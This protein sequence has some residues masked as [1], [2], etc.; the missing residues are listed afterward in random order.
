M[1][2]ATTA[3]QS[4]LCLHLTDEVTEA[5]RAPKVTKLACTRPQTQVW[6]ATN[7]RLSLLLIGPFI[8]Q[9]PECLPYARPPTVPVKQSRNIQRAQGQ[10]PQVPEKLSNN[11]VIN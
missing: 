4:W 6:P 11:Y 8:Q 5:Q 7:S 2:D 9:T 1:P 10:A 3:L